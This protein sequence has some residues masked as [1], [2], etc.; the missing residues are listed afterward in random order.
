MRLILT[1]RDRLMSLGS[2]LVDEFDSL[3][4]R[5]RSGWK[6]EHAEDGVVVGDVER[7]DDHPAVGMGGQ[8][9]VAERVE[10]VR[11]TGAQ[12]QV[13]AA[14][15]ELAGHL[16]TEAAAGAGD[17]GRRHGVSWAGATGGG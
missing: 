4:S 7:L 10:A 16:G 9:L 11:T 3:I 6:V 14:G 1:Q 8:D 15:G 17:E 12:R 13:V 2:F 5:I